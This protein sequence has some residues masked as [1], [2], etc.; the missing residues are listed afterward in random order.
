VLNP[1]YATAHQ[2]YSRLLVTTGRY[3][4]AVLEIRR[5]EMLDPLSLI[6]I[7]ETGGVYADS[8]RL[9]DAVAECRRAIDLDSSF[10]FA[11]YVLAGALLRQGKLDEAIRESESAWRLGEDPRSLVRLGIA[12]RAAGRNQD[13]EKVLTDLQSLRQKRFVPSYGIAT[14]EIALGRTSDALDQLKQAS[15]EIPP[16]QYHRLLATDPLLDPVRHAAGFADL[17]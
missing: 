10:A 17:R 4:D 9:D 11:H 12:Y 15:Q 8:G 5:A 6:I 3:N 16:G 14:L 7:A 13:A 2:W 1:S